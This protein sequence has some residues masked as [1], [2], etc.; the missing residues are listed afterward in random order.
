MASDAHDIAQDLFISFGDKWSKVRLHARNPGYIRAAAR[1]R[2]ID[3][4][5][6][7]RNGREV[8]VDHQLLD[9]V[10]RPA[11]VDERLADGYEHLVQVLREHLSEQ[12]RRAVVLMA[13]GMKYSE[14]AA[15]MGLSSGTVAAHIYTARKR[16]EGIGKEALLA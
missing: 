1:N 6:K 4:Y 16:L 2:M 11:A 15:E 14:I 13:S 5:R 9:A 3:Y 10:S 7:S 12:Q 8:P